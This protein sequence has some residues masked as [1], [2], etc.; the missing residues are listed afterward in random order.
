LKAY[1]NTISGIASEMGWNLDDDGVPPAGRVIVAENRAD[2][3]NAGLVPFRVTYL[4]NKRKQSAVVLVAPDKADT[5]RDDLL[6]KNYGGGKI[7][8]VTA[9]R[10]VKY[11]SG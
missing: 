9:P 2:A 5:A 7:S 1:P 10:R 8:K 11:V 3:M 6:G 4:K